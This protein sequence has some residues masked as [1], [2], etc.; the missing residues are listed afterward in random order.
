MLVLNLNY[1]LAGSQ[2]REVLLSY[3][4]ITGSIPNVT[5][6]DGQLDALDLTFN[7]ISGLPARH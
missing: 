5:T 2:I 4:N 3:N 1:T 7:Q 6:L